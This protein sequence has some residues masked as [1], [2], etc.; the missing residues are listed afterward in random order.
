MS[1]P[2]LPCA[3][4]AAMAAGILALSHFLMP[5]APEL[6]TRTAQPGTAKAEFA[7]RVTLE[8]YGNQP[9]TIDPR[10]ICGGDNTVAFSVRVRVMEASGEI[11][12]LSSNTVEFI[13]AGRYNA[14]WGLQ[15]VSGLSAD[16]F[17]V[18]LTGGGTSGVPTGSAPITFTISDTSNGGTYLM[19]VEVFAA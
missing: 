14:G 16:D 3:A 12:D 8:A 1:D 11:S 17:E 18:E 19:T 15:V 7:Q 10:A 2:W 6:L 5:T 13:L 9:I 4:I